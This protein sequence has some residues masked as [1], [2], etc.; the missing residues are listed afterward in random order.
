MKN[1]FILDEAA[2]DLFE[3]LGGIDESDRAVVENIDQAG[4]ASAL[5][6]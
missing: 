2:H 5:D 1:D 3:A 6:R 4:L